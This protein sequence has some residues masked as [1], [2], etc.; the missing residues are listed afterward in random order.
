M[1]PIKLLITCKITFPEQMP[2]GSGA[3]VQKY[4]IFFS[5]SIRKNQDISS[6]KITKKCPAK[7]KL[8]F[9][10]QKSPPKVC[11]FSEKKN[12]TKNTI[13]RKL[14]LSEILSGTYTYLATCVRTSTVFVPVYD[15][16]A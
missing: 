2:S 6:V 15:V 13:F 8:V 5:G 16:N 3:S 1:L 14:Q 10:G 9:R 4:I 12:S 7:I 11:K